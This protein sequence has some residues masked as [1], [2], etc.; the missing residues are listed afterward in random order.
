MAWNSNRG[1][2]QEFKEQFTHRF[3]PL[4]LAQGACKALKK[5]K[6]GQK[7]V[8]EYKAK[9]DKQSSLT[10]WLQ[11]DLRTHFYNGLSDSIKDM[12]AITNCPIETLTELFE[13]AQIVDMR[14]CQHTAEKKG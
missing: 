9:F 3:I 4:N 1:A 7:S 12:L 14:M 11:I 6:Q 10:K 8:A 5:L 2:W 13:S